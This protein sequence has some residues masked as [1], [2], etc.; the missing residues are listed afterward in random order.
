MP[1]KYLALELKL[2]VASG[3]PDA[4][5]QP[6]SDSFYS[7]SLA[8]HLPRYVRDNGAVLSLL[9]A[10]TRGY[11]EACESTAN[12]CFVFGNDY[13]EAT[14]VYLRDHPSREAALRFGIVSSILGRHLAAEKMA[15]GAARAAE[16][17]VTLR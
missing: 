6:K 2:L 12:H 9:A 4:E 11:Y 17:T 13:G 10:Q 1:D 3:V 7:K 14:V 16:A 5:Y 15:A 8:A